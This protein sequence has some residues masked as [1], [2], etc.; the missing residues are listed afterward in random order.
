MSSL[1]KAFISENSSFSITNI[2]S[3]NT[4][5]NR[6]LSYLLCWYESNNFPAIMILDL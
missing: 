3:S 1:S 4:D 5:P 6:Q 2:P